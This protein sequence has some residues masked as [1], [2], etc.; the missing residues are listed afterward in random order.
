MADPTPAIPP[1]RPPAPPSPASSG[2]LLATLVLVTLPASALILW[3][4]PLEEHPMVGLSIL[5][6]FGIMILFGALALTATV[7][8]RLSLSCSTEPLAL[9]PGSIRATI[10]LALIVLFAMISV[11]LYRSLNQPYVVEH[12][13]Y[14]QKTA[15]VQEPKNQ[16]LGV[17][18]EPCAP[19]P[20]SAPATACKAEDMLYTVHLRLP[21]GAESTDLAKQLLIIIGTLMTSVTSFYFASRSNDATTKTLAAA[22]GA[23]AGPAAT[24]APAAKAADG[25]PPADAHGDGDGHED[26]CDAPITNPTSDVDLPPAMGG[27]ATACAPAGRGAAS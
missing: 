7:F 17:L 1:P 27:V 12:L 24:P 15:L 5:A 2:T 21:A 20:A 25:T 4:K 11:M 22:L 23:A 3:L 16:V 6:I 9:P 26:G 10:A 19:R 18:P 8:E 13:G 14:E